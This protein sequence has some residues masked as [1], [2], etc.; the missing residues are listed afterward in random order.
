M[1][2][3]VYLGELEEEPFYVF[4]QP[5]PSFWDRLFETLAGNFS[6]DI[7]G[8]S[9]NCCSGGDMDHEDGLP[10]FSVMTATGQPR[11]IVAEWL[12]LAP[13]VSVVAYQMD[14][15]FVGW[16]TPVGGTSSIRL[17]QLPDDIVFIAFNAAGEE[18]NRFAT[19]MSSDRRPTDPIDTRGDGSDTQAAFASQGL[20]IELDDVPSQLKEVI[21]LRAGDQLFRVPIDG[22]DVY[23]VVSQQRGQAYAESCST[24]T[25]YDIP[26]DLQATCL[27]RTVNGQIERGVFHYPEDTE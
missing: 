7:L 15:E 18:V 17:D 14:G 26:E 1:E 16:Q 21:D 8:T 10:G 3:A 6:G 20:A 12:G 24:L 2:R 19:S 11:L 27:E 5:A 22:Q 9:L 13:D 25:A 23:V 4:S